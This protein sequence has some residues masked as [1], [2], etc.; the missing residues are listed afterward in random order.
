MSTFYIIFMLLLIVLPPVFKAIEK[1]LSNAGQDNGARQVKRMRE[2]LFNEEKENKDDGNDNEPCPSVSPQYE[3]EVFPVPDYIYIR[4]GKEAES[5]SVAAPKV[6]AIPQELLEGGYM[7]VRDIV[8]K[9]S[10]AGNIQKAVVTGQEN[11]RKIDPKKLVL[12][13]EIMKTKF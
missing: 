6:T 12:Y 13:S 3:G 2:V 10:A 9:R 4:D 1:A 7:S 5:E 8:E 11:V